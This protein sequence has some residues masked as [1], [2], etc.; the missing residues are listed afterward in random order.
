MRSQ[1]LYAH[2][3]TETHAS[4]WQCKQKDREIALRA[5]YG[6]PRP[7]TLPMESCHPQ[8]KQVWS[9]GG[10]VLQGRRGSVLP[11]QD[12]HTS[13]PRLPPPPDDTS[14]CATVGGVIHLLLRIAH[15]GGVRQGSNFV[16][17]RLNIENSRRCI[18]EGRISK[19][20][21]NGA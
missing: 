12:T 1:S 16:G 4:S 15:V 11:A 6:G 7:S 10:C 19:S 21:K 13:P 18:R 2:V 9:S 20:R 5:L 8:S 3:K 17:L 14:R